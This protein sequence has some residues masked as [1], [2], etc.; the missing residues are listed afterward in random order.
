MLT[1]LERRGDLTLRNSSLSGAPF[2]ISELWGI[3]IVAGSVD[4]S[5]NGVFKDAPLREILDSILLSNGYGYR[6]VG[7]SLVVSKLEQ[8]GQVNPFMVS[9][10]ISVSSASV[11]DVVEGAKLLVTPNGQILRDSFGAQHLRARLPRPR[12]DD[13]RVRDHHRCGGAG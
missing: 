2:T 7:A 8:L 10:T 12:A 13:S 9:A 3:N 4:G 6:S 1:A 5:V 11:D